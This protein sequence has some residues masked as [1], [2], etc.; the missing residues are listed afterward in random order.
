MAV[1]SLLQDILHAPT[2]QIP[3]A[4]PKDMPHQEGESVSPNKS[5]DT[6]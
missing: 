4:T 2:V 6:L 1:L 5:D 3:L